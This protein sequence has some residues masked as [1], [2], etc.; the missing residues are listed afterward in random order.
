MWLSGGTYHD[1]A[2]FLGRWATGDAT[3]IELLPVVDPAE[4][5]PET[6]VRLT[7]RLTGALSTRLQDWADRLTRSMA[8]ETDEFSV[9][10]ALAQARA[11]LH[12]IRAL[13]DHRAL[14][15][16]LRRRLVEIV[17]RQIR[18]TQVALEDDLDRF[19]ARGVSSRIVEARRRTIRDNP[20]TAVLSQPPGPAVESG[21]GSTEWML[22]PAAPR[23]RRVIL[24]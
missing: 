20:L 12:S 3:G 9:G 18:S 13:A 22:D 24:D 19:A 11:G 7:D 8:A 2:G 4:L 17:D 14:P 21:P 5:N 6:L 16:E 10:R 1:W 23:H 15:E